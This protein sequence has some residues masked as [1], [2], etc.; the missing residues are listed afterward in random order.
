MIAY[1]YTR[2]LVTKDG[3]LIA[4]TADFFQAVS[5]TRENNGA[6]KTETVKATDSRKR[7]EKTAYNTALADMEIALYNSKA[8]IRRDIKAMTDKELVEYLELEYM[9]LDEYINQ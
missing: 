3:E 2:Y 8:D 9:T 6:I 1:K 5:I 7:L 4:N